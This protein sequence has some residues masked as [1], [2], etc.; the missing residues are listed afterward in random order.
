MQPPKMQ[1]DHFMG[2]LL[3]T[4]H[5]WEHRELCHF[6]SSFPNS[7]LSFLLPS[8]IHSYLYINEQNNLKR[9]NLTRLLT[10]CR[11]K[12]LLFHLQHRFLLSKAF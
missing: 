4:S 6:P 5:T 9:Q 2:N 1:S 7:M 11:A 3:V 12:L 8:S 10:N